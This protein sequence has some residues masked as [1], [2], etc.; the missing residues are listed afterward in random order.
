MKNQD[1][2]NFL[3]E[4]LKALWGYTSDKLNI[5]V[6]QLNKD[7]IET[8]LNQRKVDAE[9]RAE[10]IQILQACEFERYAPATET[11]HMGE[12]Y[13]KT[14]KVITQMENTI[15]NVHVKK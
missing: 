12:L 9:A 4:V 7:N 8:Q 15:N 2:E 11:Q 6:S 1:K 3:D 13:A 5:P 14:L 10:F